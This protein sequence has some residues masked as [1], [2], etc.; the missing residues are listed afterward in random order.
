MT[1]VSFRN[2]GSLYFK[3]DLIQ[4]SIPS[5]DLQAPPLAPSSVLPLHASISEFAMGPST[6]AA[7]WGAERAT[8]S[9]LNRGP[10]K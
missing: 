2:H 1:S 5:R 9:E 10:C 7:L 3:K 4:H 6:T 8:M